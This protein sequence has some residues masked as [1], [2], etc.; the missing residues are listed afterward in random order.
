MAGERLSIL[1]R[2]AGEQLVVGGKS[3]V[4]G[5]IEQLRTK[6]ALW[7]VASNEAPGAA[8][9]CV[10]HV[11]EAHKRWASL[12]I[13]PA[14]A[15]R[16]ESIRQGLPPGRAQAQLTRQVA[17]EALGEETRT[18]GAASGEP[19]LV[20]VWATADEWSDVEF[21]FLRDCL[22]FL[23]GTAGSHEPPHLVLDR[24]IGAVDETVRKAM[25]L[26]LRHCAAEAG[27]GIVIS[28]AGDDMEP[29]VGAALLEARQLLLPVEAS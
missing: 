22:A 13:E 21:G 8:D 16:L 7:L 4:G 18:H 14:L 17:L 26:T 3:S 23:S 11:R 12:A 28:N 2:A 9:W 27:A 1:P 6:Q 25:L 19:S 20:C 10:L 24:V 15:G 29:E 5:L